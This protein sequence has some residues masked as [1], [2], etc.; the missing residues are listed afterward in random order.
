MGHLR[1]WKREVARKILRRLVSVEDPVKIDNKVFTLIYSD[2][3]SGFPSFVLMAWR[4]QMFWG[5]GI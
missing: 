3:Y 1:N 4:K 2:S 5:N